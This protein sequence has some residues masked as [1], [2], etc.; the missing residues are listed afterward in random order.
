MAVGIDL[1]YFFSWPLV[2]FIFATRLQGLK[3]QR[4]PTWF[5]TKRGY[6]TYVGGYLLS[7][8]QTL[9]VWHCH[10]LG[11]PI[12][13]NPTTNPNERPT[14]RW[15]TNKAVCQGRPIQAYPTT[16]PSKTQQPIQANPTTAMFRQRWPTNDGQPT[17][18]NQ[19]WPIQQWPIHQWPIHQNQQRHLAD[20]KT[21]D[22]QSS[23]QT[24]DGPPE[25]RGEAKYYGLP[26]HLLRHITSLCTPHPHAPHAAIIAIGIGSPSNVV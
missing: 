24:N 10:T 8:V 7:N 18:D 20:S 19:R 9:G 17:M 4:H 12:Q 1:N 15:P 16:N 2:L 21:N 23:S 11:R 6:G 22:G 25:T 3:T 5:F 26:I 13:A 14:Q